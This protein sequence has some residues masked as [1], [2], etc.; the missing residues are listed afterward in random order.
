[1]DRASLG[2]FDFSRLPRSWA[3]NIAPSG[4][5]SMSDGIR[6]L[7]GI[8]RR[9]RLNWSSFDQTRFRTVFAMSER[10]NT[11][12]LVGGFED[13]AEHSQEVIATPSVQ[14]QSSDRLTRQHV[15]RSSFRT[16]GSALR[17]RASGKSPLISIQDSDDE[18]ALEERRSPIS[19]IPGSEDETAVAT[20]K[21][22]RS[23]KGALPGPSRPR[24]VPEGDGSLFADQG[25]LISLAGRMRS[26]GCRL[27]SLASS[28][29]KE[30]YA[31]VMEAF[32]EYV[33]VM[34]D[35]VV[36]SRN[37]KEIESIGFEIKRILK[38]LKAT[39]REGKKDT[40]KIEAL[41]EDWKRIHQENEALMAQMVAQ[42]ARIA[43][44]E[45]ERDRDIRRASRIARRD[46]LESLKDKWTTKKKGVSAEIQLHEVNASID[47]LN[48]LKDGAA[49]SDWSISKLDLP[50]VSD[51]SVDQVGGSSVPDDS[52]STFE[53]L[54]VWVV[55]IRNMASR[56]SN[57]RNS[58]R[59]QN[60]TGSA[61]AERIRSGDVSEALTE[62]LREETR[63]PRTSTQEAKDL[64]GE[65]S[66]ARVKS[67]SPTGPEMDRGKGK[68][69]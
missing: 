37:D 57:P 30:A 9:D 36:A 20:R 26:A 3:E 52:A 64:E 10:T 58:D 11:A 62:V 61:N 13:E 25:D 45:V 53:I 46:I 23:S 8:L 15:R 69:P 17:D 29:K 12:P 60:R 16:S 50:E 42:K 67:S 4:S 7:I 5:S 59:V 39:K 19:L 56:R 1:M 28:A 43:A 21:R 49:V 35:H 33:V 18:N 27:L 54:F 40:E 63:L 31:K 44:L 6:G 68:A 48:E 14:A 22:R 24:F 66:I 65:K 47:L 34:E 51:D 38:E 41:I 2:E 32:N 55:V